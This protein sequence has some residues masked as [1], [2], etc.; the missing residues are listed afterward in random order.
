MQRRGRK[1]TDQGPIRAGILAPLAANNPGRVLQNLVDALRA[2]LGHL[3]CS[4]HADGAG[5]F[6]DTVAGLG[7]CSGVERDAFAKIGF[8]GRA[9][10]IDFLKVNNLGHKRR[11]RHQSPN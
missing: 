5:G 11:C 8:L 7:H 6:Q 4:D 2:A 9:R 1:P 10:D 3:L